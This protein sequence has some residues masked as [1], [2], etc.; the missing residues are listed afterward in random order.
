[1]KPRLILNSVDPKDLKQG[2]VYLLMW[3]IDGKP[4]TD[5]A[6]WDG[7]KWVLDENS[8]AVIW[9][10][11]NPDLIFEKPN[12]GKISDSM[13]MDEYDKESQAMAIYPNKGCN[14]PYTTLGLCGE[15]G[16][17]A[18]KVKKSLRDAKGDI[19]EEMRTLML[20]ELGD[21]MW[22]ITASATELG[23]HLEEIAQMNLDKLRDRTAKGTRQG[24]GDNR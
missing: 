20:K 9:K 11:G 16:E 5:K 15:A 2:E 8:D 13:T 21:V 6:I 23:A 17:F 19:S 18:E 22:Y 24:S 4:E 14:L 12:K 7:V 10:Y 3:N 1:M